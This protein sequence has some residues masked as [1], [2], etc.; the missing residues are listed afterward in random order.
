[1]NPDLILDGEETVVPAEVVRNSVEYITEEIRE[2]YCGDEIPWIIGYSGG[3]DSTCILQLIWNAIATLAP[4]KR[5]KPI[6]VISTDTLVENP[7]VATWVKQSHRN[8]ETA[9]DIQG[10]PIKPHLLYPV[11]QDTFWVNLI[12]KGYPAPRQKFRW[13]TDRLK[14]KPANRFVREQ[15]KASGEV[16]LVLGTRRAESVAR[17]ANMKKHQ[18]GRVRDRLTA[19]ASSS[20]CVLYTPI[21]D[22]Q[23]DHVWLYLNQWENPWGQSNKD[24]FVMYR[25]ATADNEC[26]LVVDTST[27]SCGDSRFG[28]WVCTLVS[29]DKSMEAMILND[30]EKEWMQPLLDLR[31]ELD[32]RGEEKREKEKQ[33]REFR[34]LTGITQVFEPKKAPENPEN[35][36][37]LVRGPY[38]KPWREYLLR[39]LLQAQE[40]SRSQ[41]PETMKEIELIRLEELKEIRRIWL[42]EKHEF[43][44]ALPGIYQ[45]VTGEEFPDTNSLDNQRMLAINSYDYLELLN[46]ACGGDSVYFEMTRNLLDIERQYLTKTRRIGIYDALEKCLAR[47]ADDEETSV[48]KAVHKYRENKSIKTAKEMIKEG[49]YQETIKAL[50]YNKIDFPSRVDE[51]LSLDLNSGN[52]EGKNSSWGAM[53]YG[54]KSHNGQED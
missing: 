19:Y 52:Q 41:A 33:H 1:M 51:Q 50:E 15:V 12:G 32:F 28:C 3:K 17:A 6:H 11:V 10:L 30:E 13:C 25:G 22:W 24:L 26:P 49:N 48:A 18:Q 21:E 4:E 47:R 44:D 36:E 8:M 29:Q 35:P 54:K 2:L 53:K 46:E 40:E 9:A 27:P 16:L 37:K 7:I 14:I 42:E 23:N 34:R 31:N 45:E 20:N 43:D 5:K 39:R 38:T